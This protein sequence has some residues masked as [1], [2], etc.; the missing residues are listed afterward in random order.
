MVR[1]VLAFLNLERRPL[2]GRLLGR[3]VQDPG[4]LDTPELRE[5]PDSSS[6]GCAAGS[7]A[8]SRGDSLPASCAE[9]S[10][11]PAR[12]TAGRRSPGRLRLGRA[13]PGRRQVPSSPRWCETGRGHVRSPYRMTIQ[14]PLQGARSGQH[15]HDE[16]ECASPARIRTVCLG[17]RRRVLGIF[18][19]PARRQRTEHRASRRAAGECT[20]RSAPC[21]G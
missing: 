9:T 18:H 7:L 12:R 16:R 4:V 2:R 3:L 20:V 11:P 13:S 8:S 17:A 14:Q 5:R 6:P 21:N 19:D 15:D 10:S 1:R